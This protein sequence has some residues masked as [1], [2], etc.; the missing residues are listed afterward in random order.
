MFLFE[1]LLKLPL[2]QNNLS[3]CLSRIFQFNN[4]LFYELCIPGHDH[5][6]RDEHPG[7]FD[8]GHRPDDDQAVENGRRESI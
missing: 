3:F 5:R 1:I 6:V 8:H 7:A 4:N 2:P